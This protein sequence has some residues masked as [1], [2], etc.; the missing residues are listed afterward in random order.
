[1]VFVKRLAALAP[2]F[3]FTRKHKK[4]RFFSDPQRA[5]SDTQTTCLNLLDYERS[6]PCA[7]IVPSCSEKRRGSSAN[8]TPRKG[9]FSFSPWLMPR[10][11]HLSFSPWQRHGK[12]VPRKE[13]ALKGHPNLTGPFKMVASSWD[14]PAGLTFL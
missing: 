13:Y 10:K 2:F 11:G 5:K 6:E 7:S 4:G 8:L 9:H 3:A 12:T 14:A 1:M